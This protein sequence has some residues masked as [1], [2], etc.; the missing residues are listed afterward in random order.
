M[1]AR[2]L[3]NRKN[4]MPNIALGTA[5]LMNELCQ[6]QAAAMAAAMSGARKKLALPPIR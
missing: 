2:R 1:P 5:R 4:T 3:K 6:L